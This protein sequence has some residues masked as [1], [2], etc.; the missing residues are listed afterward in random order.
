[1]VL[2]QDESA[3]CGDLQDRVN[4]RSK[5]CVRI[6]GGDKSLAGL[7]CDREAV[8]VFCALFGALFGSSSF[9]S[10][11]LPMRKGTAADAPSALCSLIQT[12]SAGTSAGI[13]TSSFPA[14]SFG[15]TFT[16]AE[17][18]ETGQSNFPLHSTVTVVPRCPPGGKT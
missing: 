18:T 17:A 8:D 11:R 15:V 10:L 4:G 14:S 16:P 13:S 9:S 6:Q 5:L 2:R 1:V 12:L 7:E 3:L